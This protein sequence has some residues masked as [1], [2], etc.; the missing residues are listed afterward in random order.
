MF[1]VGAITL[2]A[3]FLVKAPAPS[4]DPPTFASVL[5]GFDFIRTRPRLLGVISLDLFVV[6][7]GGATALLPIFARD[8]LQSGRSALACCARRPRRA[9]C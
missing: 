2:F 1:F 7:L 4:R 6:L 3:S 9:R 5:A 8:I